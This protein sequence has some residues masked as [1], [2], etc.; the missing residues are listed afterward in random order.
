MRAMSLKT[1]ALVA[2][3]VLTGLFLGSYFFLS[4]NPDL[5]ANL[6]LFGVT[7]VSF[8]WP[9]YFVLRLTERKP[10][11]P[12]AVPPANITQ[13][14]AQQTTIQK[15]ILRDISKY[16]YLKETHM[17]DQLTVLRLGVKGD[18]ELPKLVGYREEDVAGR[19]GLVLRFD[20]PHVPFSKW[21]ERQPKLDTFFGKDVDIQL[22]ESGNQTI[23]I[24]MVTKKAATLPLS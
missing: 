19:Y 18:P 20:S 7:Y 6:G 9:A 14:R 22:Q 13:L 16:L 10:I 12:T 3:V 23:E 17:Q 4:S 2:A 8:I 21:Q 15:E 24:V 11:R 1:L 5:Q